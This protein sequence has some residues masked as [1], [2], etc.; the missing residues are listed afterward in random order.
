MADL[1]VDSSSPPAFYL[2]PN[3]TRARV[4]SFNLVYCDALTCPWGFDGS[5]TGMTILNYGTATGG[6]AGDLTG[7]Y[8]CGGCAAACTTPN[9]TM[10]YAGLWTIGAKTYPAWTWDSGG[11][12]L[13]FNAN[14]CD[15]KAGCATA[16]MVNLNFWVDVHAC[17]TDRATIA[18]GPG[19]NPANPVPGGVSDEWTC[20]QPWANI[21]DPAPKTIL[22]TLKTA[23]RAAAAPGDTVTYTLYYG[24]SGTSPLTGITVMDTMPPAVHYVFGSAVPAP[25]TFWDPNPGPPFALKWTFPGSLPTAGGPTSRIT[26]QVTVDWGNEPFDTGSGSFAAAENSRLG[27]QA[28]V[29]FEGSTCAAKSAVSPQADIVV[30]RFLFWQEADND[31]VYSYSLGQPPDEI[32]YSV[33]LKNI[34][35]TKTWWNV[36]IWDTVPAELDSWCANCGLEDPCLGWTMTPSGCAAAAAGRRVS[37]ANTVLTWNLDMPPGMTLTLR[38]KA[39]VRPSAPAGGT[40]ISVVS[41]Q[42]MGYVG[43]NGTNDSL[44]PS[45]FTH[46]A[47]IFLPTTYISYTAFFGA[48]KGNTTCPGIFLPFWPLNKKADFSLYGIEVIG[49]GGWAEFGGVS[50]PI[51]NY[52]GSCTGGFTGFSPGG[53]P[54]CKIERIPAMYK[55]LNKIAICPTFPYHFVYKVVSNSPILWQMRALVES[56]NQDHHLYDPA[57]TISFRGFTFYSYRL[58]SAAGGVGLGSALL[59]INTSTNAT[60]AYQSGLATAVHFFRWNPGTLSYDYQ[61]TTDL[62]AESAGVLA[63]GTS[64]AEEGFYRLLSSQANLI[65]HHSFNAYDSLAASGCCDNFGTIAPNRETGNLVTPNGGGG[66]VYAVGNPWGSPKA[67]AGWTGFVVGNTGTVNATY[68]VW[69]Y[70]P[71]GTSPAPVPILLGG[72]SGRWVN[73]AMD[74]VDAGMFAGNPNPPNPHAYTGCY[75]LAAFTGASTA[76]FKVEL[77]SGGPIQVYCGTFIPSVF[78]GGSVIHSADGFQVGTKFWHHSVGDQGYNCGGGPNPAITP[79]GVLD[80]FCPKQGMVVRAQANDGYS[81]TYTTTASDE[82]VAFMRLSFLNNCNVKRPFQIDILAGGAG[83]AL[84]NM[85]MATEKGYTSPFVQTGVHYLLVVPPVVYAGQSFWITVVVVNQTNT[86]ETEYCGTTSFTSTD[87][88]AKIESTNMETYNYAWD[89]NDPA[90]TCLGAGCTNGCDNGVKLFFNVTFNRLGQHAIVAVDT[91]DGSITGYATFVVVGADIKLEK[92]PRFATAASGDTVRFRICWSNYS[93]AS[94]F[95]FTINDA[96]PVGMSFLPEAGTWALNCGGSG[97]APVLAVAYSTATTPTLPAAA[98]FVQANPV[99]ATRWLRWTVATIGIN[100]TGCACF[101]VQVQ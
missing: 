92:S 12:P 61:S 83:I 47:P 24:R 43:F 15:A 66:N 30:R 6:A 73:T 8:W 101:R 16:C 1:N 69:R 95:S 31:I 84:Y 7:L 14:P 57:S 46:L 36:Q 62:A 5:I 86:T 58:A 42:E 74:T 90:A 11:A 94:G 20:V 2:F 33:F 63:M 34:S 21:Q 72:T 22:Y 28:E 68:R 44:E 99:A 35:T 51:S 79:L 88:T 9:Q 13:V 32:T 71:Y 48:D 3:W 39:Q 23:D 81:A 67:A 37:G 45:N 17:P 85:C 19:Y 29:F 78:A 93:S 77:V 64:A 18:L 26:F 65:V 56:D 89:S 41:V 4:A 100:Q 27:N 91:L 38:W 70:E 59:A 98:S 53:T 10:T 97:A 55:P 54:G 25:D 40:A 50:P 75:D 52:I 60:F 49:G 82:V 80:I 76:L 96:V 87:P